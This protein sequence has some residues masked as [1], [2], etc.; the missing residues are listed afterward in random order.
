MDLIP[1]RKTAGPAAGDEERQAP[2]DMNDFGP[3]APLKVRWMI[4][5]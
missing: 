2:Q 4:L 3:V 1:K 5:D